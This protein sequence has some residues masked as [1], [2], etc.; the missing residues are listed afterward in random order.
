MSKG[1]WKGMKYSF[2]GAIPLN[3]LLILAFNI[4][5]KLGVIHTEVTNPAFIIGVYTIVFLIYIVA[6]IFYFK[7]QSSENLEKLKKDVEGITGRK[8]T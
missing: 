8:L 4:L 6:V 5:Q 7:R 3:L 2:L 1:F